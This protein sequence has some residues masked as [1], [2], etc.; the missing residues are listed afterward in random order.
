M[1]LATPTA[2]NLPLETLDLARIGQFTFRAPDPARYPALQIARDGDGN[3]RA[4][5]VPSSMPP[6]KRPWT[7]S[8]TKKRIG[9][10]D[11]ARIVASGDRK[12]VRRRPRKC[13]DFP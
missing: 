9:F 7:V 12:Y 3:A 13:R 4:W 5:P 10:T 6:R 2:P 11:M 8:L 1:P